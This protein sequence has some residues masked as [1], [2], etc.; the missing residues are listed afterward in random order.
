MPG[1][2][3][4]SPALAADYR[5]TRALTLALAAPLGPEDQC[6]QSMPDA[7]PTKWHL[8]HTTW[9]FETFVLAGPGFS[10]YRPGWDY[11]FN[12]YYQTLGAMHPRPLR[13]L[14]S[15]P[16][17]A[18]I[19]AY[20]AWVDEQVLAL[21]ERDAASPEQRARIVLGLHHEQQHQELLL[22][23]AKHLLAQNPL[24]PA[25]RAGGRPRPA[26]SPTPPADAWVEDPGGLIEI[27]RPSTNVGFGFDNEG[28]RH[29][30]WLAPFAL[31]RRPVTCGQYLGFIADGGYRRTELW[32]AAG[33][34]TV[35][36]E[37][38]TAPGYW[39][40]EPDGDPDDASGWREFT[41]DGL[42]PLD[43]D[44]PVVHLSFYEADAFARWAGARLPSEAEWEHLAGREPV[45]GNLLPVDPE[46]L[47][48]AP[49][50]STA[51][52]ADADV[53]PLAQAFGDVWEWTASPYL[54][55]P[56][57]RPPAGAVGEYN[58]KF[59]AD[60]WVLRGGSCATPADHVR[61]T[62]RNF[63]P[64]P[65]RWQFAGVRLAADR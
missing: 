11:L 52:T 61:A 51:S 28:P 26:T 24:S 16:T 57:Y 50:H 49:L 54:G 35:R 3:S 46:G 64:S 19:L 2:V 14:L 65:T 60:Q 48:A 29:T 10:A 7:S 45:T 36:R 39:R 37:G 55:Y 8:A 44:A 22:T 56:G 58:G 59:M 53:G 40:A 23:D 43:L 30:L 20:R 5:R 33:W 34:D 4:G 15:R 63:F 38:W 62:Y 25:Y 41:L 12:S 1:P 17:V 31:A 6:V 47:A 21:L 42:V 32:L 27:G 18:E 13:G 9:F